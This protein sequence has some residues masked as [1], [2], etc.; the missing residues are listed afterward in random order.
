MLEIRPQHQLVVSGLY[1]YVRHPMYAD[2]LLWVVSFGLLTAN[3]F[4]SLTMSVG[5]T[6]LFVVRIPDEE[7]L[8]I[9]QFGDQYRHY[10][11]T[12]KRLIPYL[13]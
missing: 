3:W 5:M 10:M 4:Y 7:K 1:R 8:M 9:D 11:K 13:F 6:I 2:M 12:T